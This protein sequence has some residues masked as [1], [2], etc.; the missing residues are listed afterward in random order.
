MYLHFGDETSI[1]FA[2]RQVKYFVLFT[3]CLCATKHFNFDHN[4]HININLNTSKFN[5]LLV[6]MC[7]LCNSWKILELISQ[8]FQFIFHSFIKTLEIIN[9]NII[10]RVAEKNS[11][12]ERIS[13]IS[14]QILLILKFNWPKR[15]YWIQSVYTFQN[16]FKN[17][18]LFNISNNEINQLLIISVFTSGI[19][20]LDNYVYY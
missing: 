9:D 12:Y 15:K 1:Y 5:L 17:K 20:R 19:A 18:K 16:Y 6:N 4:F 3:V 7:V 2:K 14:F 8:F 13:F 11:I 10:L